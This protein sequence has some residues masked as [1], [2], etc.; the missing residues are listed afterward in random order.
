MFE[1]RLKTPKIKFPPSLV[2]QEIMI[3][4]GLQ[5]VNN[6]RE[7]LNRGEGAENMAIIKL[8]P[9]SVITQWKKGSDIPL[10]DTTRM[11]SAFRVDTSQTTD[12]KAVMNFPPSEAWKA[13]IHQKGITIKPK[14]EGGVLAIPMGKEVFGGGQYIFLREVTIPPR[15]HVGFSQKDIDD[16]AKMIDV[17]VYAKLEKEIDIEHIA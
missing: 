6:Y 13:A 16:A 4:A 1:I 5:V 12:T 11:V 17:K 14:K 3:A 8:K 7:R 2:T 15:P 9:L 10:I